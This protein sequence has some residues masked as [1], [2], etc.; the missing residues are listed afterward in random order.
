MH[1]RAAVSF[2]G[3]FFKFTVTTMVRFYVEHDRKLLSIT[4]NQER[5]K[6]C[7][8]L[9]STQKFVTKLVSPA[10]RRQLTLQSRILLAYLLTMFEPKWIGKLMDFGPTEAY[11]RRFHDADDRRLYS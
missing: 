11:L 5:F 3:Q 9:G 6:I 1:L 7:D 2:R 4:T 8:V 10:G